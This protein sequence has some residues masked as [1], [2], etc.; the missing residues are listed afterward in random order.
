MC[1]TSQ[2]E[3]VG[4]SRSFDMRDHLW[5]ERNGVWLE[6]VLTWGKAQVIVNPEGRARDSGLHRHDAAAIVPP[7]NQKTP[8]TVKT[9]YVSAIPANKLKTSLDSKTQA[10]QLEGYHICNV[11]TVCPGRYA[12]N[13]LSPAWLDCTAFCHE[14]AH[15]RKYSR[16]ASGQTMDKTIDGTVQEMSGPLQTRH[17]CL[18][19]AKR[20]DLQKGDSK[21]SVGHSYFVL[22]NHWVVS[23]RTTWET[24][25]SSSC[26]QQFFW[27]PTTGLYQPTK[28]RAGSTIHRNKGTN[29]NPVCTYLTM[30]TVFKPNKIT[31]TVLTSAWEPM[32]HF[33]WS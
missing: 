31:C 33:F 3:R 23:G 14:L 2:R 8:S 27:G 9:A 30:T 16:L 28:E 19:P 32:L 21:L 26:L 24:P 6:L 22:P 11:P 18:Q 13:L 20:S 25:S 1:R 29:K 7:T 15:W 10:H 5:S 17:I 12:S 4:R